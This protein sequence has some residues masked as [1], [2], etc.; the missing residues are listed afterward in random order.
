MTAGGFMNIVEALHSEEAKLERQLMA[1][2]G[3]IAALNGGN[4]SAVS[5]VHT[6]STNGA[7]AKRTMSAAVR[8]KIARSAKA[9]WAKIKAEKAKKAK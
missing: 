8:A 2:K 9:R 1:V 4:T 5:P 6:S 7:T 3:A